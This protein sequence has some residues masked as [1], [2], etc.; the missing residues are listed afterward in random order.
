VNGGNASPLYKYLKK[1]SDKLEIG[2]NFV[3]FLVVDGRPVKRYHSR[4]SP[5][6]IEEDILSYLEGEEWDEGADE[7]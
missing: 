4:I 5:K 1:D 3:K 7:L 2:W 6:K